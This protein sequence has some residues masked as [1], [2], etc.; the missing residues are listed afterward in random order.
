MKTENK[1]A[2]KAEK[3]DVMEELLAAA[4]EAEKHY[5]PTPVSIRLRNAIARAQALDDLRCKRDMAVR[6]GNLP[7][8]LKCAIAIDKKRG[9]Y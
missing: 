5:L 3:S 8:A 2:K 4:V 6:N 1:N 7:R 9:L